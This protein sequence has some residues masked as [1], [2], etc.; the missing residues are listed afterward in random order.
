MRIL[1]INKIIKHNTLSITNIQESALLTQENIE[2][3][4]YIIIS[5]GD[6]TIR[7]V[8]K[9][10]HQLNYHTPII[11]NP[12]G[13][14]N[15]IT[16]LHRIPKLASVLQSLSEGKIPPTKNQKYYSINKEIFLFSAGNMGDLQ[17]I[18]LSETLRFGMLKNSI[19]KYILAAL[20]LLPVHLIMTPF[21]LMSKRKFFIF[22]PLS[23]L[24]K[25]GNF[26]GQVPELEIDLEN[27]Y[28][29]IELDGDIVTIEESILNI[30]HAGNIEILV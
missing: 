10:L 29:H 14:F 22:T 8:V 30:H 11:L 19:A 16:K 12:T 18:L 24:P 25:F 26:Y 3:F 21:M 20:F 5:G 13:S 28:N 4:N 17:H 15:V 2:D 1:S 9:M 7:R 23:F 6:G 27:H